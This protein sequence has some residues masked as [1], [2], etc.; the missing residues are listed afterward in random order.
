M[1]KSNATTDKSN[2]T[3]GR[4]QRAEAN[5]RGSNPTTANPT[6]RRRV[7]A[8]DGDSN[9]PA[10]TRAR[11]PLGRDINADSTRPEVGS[12]GFDDTGSTTRRRV[13]RGGYGFDAEDM[14]ST[15]R[16]WRR[17]RGGGKDEKEVEKTRWRWRTATGWRE[18]RRGREPE[19]EVREN[20][21]VEKKRG[22]RARRRGGERNR[23]ESTPALRNRPH[24]DAD[25]VDTSNP[26]AVAALPRVFLLFCFHLIRHNY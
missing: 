9:S 15:K 13:R 22:W 5:N 2:T 20:K 17:R 7:G 25:E 16:R 12:I 23:V 3:V 21:E 24:S 10:I 18:Q 26:T 1:A 14:G 11:P 8:N 4:R 6:Q 19:E